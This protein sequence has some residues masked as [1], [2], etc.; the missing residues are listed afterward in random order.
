MRDRSWSDSAAGRSARLLLVRV[1]EPGGAVWGLIAVDGVVARAPFAR[2]V[3]A[4]MR[5][6]CEWAL[7]EGAELSECVTEALVGGNGGTG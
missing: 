3:G 7:Y 6:I 4:T 1:E 2:F 5:Q